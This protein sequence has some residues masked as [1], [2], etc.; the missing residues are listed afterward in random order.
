[1][2]NI[3]EQ[4]DVSCHTIRDILSGKNWKHITKDFP[5]NIIR[6]KAKYDRGG[7]NNSNTKLNTL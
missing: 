7:V 2:S 1:M 6:E 5:L 4:Y 3:A